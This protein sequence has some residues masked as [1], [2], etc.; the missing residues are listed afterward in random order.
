M[1]DERTA[2]VLLDR[3]NQARWREATERACAR[4]WLDA[5]PLVSW[6]GVEMT[7]FT[8]GAAVNELAAIAAVPRGHGDQPHLLGLGAFSFALGQSRRTGVLDPGDEVEVDDADFDA[9]LSAAVGGENKIGSREGTRAYPA[10]DHSDFKIEEL[11]AVAR[12]RAEPLKVEEVAG[13]LLIA[14]AVGK[15]G[16]GLGI[17]L[18]ALKGARPI[19][20]LVS[21]VIGFQ[22]VFQ[23]MME[24]GLIPP[25]ACEF[26]SIA[27]LERSR[28]ASART[29]VRRA[30]V[31]IP[32]TPDEPPSKWV[33]SKAF[34]SH[35]PI[36]IDAPSLD[37]IP[38]RLQDAATLILDTGPL[39]PDLIKRMVEILRGVRPAATIN[40]DDCRSLDLVD[41]RMAFRPG[42]GPDEIIN[43]LRRYG[44]ENRAE[45]NPSVND[46]PDRREPRSGTSFR[47]GSPVPPSTVIEP[48][49]DPA[50][51]RVEELAGYGEA[52][53]W[54]EDLKLDL[55][56]WR[57]G[58]VVWADLSPR[59]LLSGPPGTGKTTWAKALRNSLQL[60]LLATSA[61]DWLT[62]GHLGDVLAAM[63]RAFADAVR[64][65]PCILF[66]DEVDGIGTRERPVRE[67]DD[68]WTSVVN[69][70]L[71]LMD[72]AI[73]TEG[74]ILIGATNR[75]EALDPALRRAGRLERHIAIPKPDTA[76]L[77]AILAHHLGEDLARMDK[78]DETTG[79]AAI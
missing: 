75:P 12:S 73:R 30:L 69:K 58:R 22:V 40:D 72:G 5:A 53:T 52:L 51:Q 57:E 67:Y 2:R 79:E 49:T 1:I 20:V 71:Q 16:V 13:A 9:A 19:P 7:R 78:S 59:L 65:S 4:S 34:E 3:L 14:K 25:G 8:R 48:S 64:R 54:A 45:E 11:V 29:T 42:L 56:D 46:R 15:L 62:G 37:V 55:D 76:T 47:A 60:P 61:A 31:N 28:L 74:V 70:A 18:D 43:T 39:D 41:L 66:I 21:P 35:L 10:V 68:Y 6:R 23:R 24:D 17:V 26:R 77:A 32:I 63:D 44:R 33:L 36:L 27:S 50:A 38:Q